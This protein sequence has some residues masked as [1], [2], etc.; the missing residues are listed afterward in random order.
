VGDE[1]TRK[2][3]AMAERPAEPGS[4]RQGDEQDTSRSDAIEQTRR[5]DPDAPALGA[6]DGAE[7]AEDLPEPQEPG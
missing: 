3:E 7:D 4:E 5:V 1:R 2:D 6:V